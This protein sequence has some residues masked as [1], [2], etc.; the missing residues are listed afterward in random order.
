MFIV[1][2]EHREVGVVKSAK[3]FLSFILVSAKMG[4]GK[5]Y[6]T[7]N[8]RKNRIGTV[9]YPKLQK[10]VCL[11]FDIVYYIDMKWIEGVFTS[12]ILMFNV[13]WNY[14]YEKQTSSFG[15]IL[16]H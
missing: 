1:I 9:I 8:I 11:F 15:L 14:Y 13:I 10:K 5:D 16:F 6:I 12:Y 4:E 7:Q 3:A 2:S